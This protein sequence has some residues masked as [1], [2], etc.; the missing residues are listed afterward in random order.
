MSKR[1]AEAR[2]S[3]AK[4]GRR[5]VTDPMDDMIAEAAQ[6]TTNTEFMTPADPRRSIEEL[7]VTIL[8]PGRAARGGITIYGT[9]RQY[10]SELAIEQTSQTLLKQD[11]FNPRVAFCRRTHVWNYNC[12][13]M[14]A[15]RLEYWGR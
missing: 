12:Q 3:S 2:G 15:W 9:I 13:M 7:G 8:G 11:D 4:S 6:T 1:G 10:A 5:D 14:N